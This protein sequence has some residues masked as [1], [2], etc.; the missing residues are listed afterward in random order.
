[1][2][3]QLIDLMFELNVLVVDLFLLDRRRPRLLLIEFV[4]KPLDHTVVEPDS[5][6]RDLGLRLIV[7]IGSV[8]LLRSVY[9]ALNS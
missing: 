5:S 2:L 3:L 6:A 4:F 7:L 8:I 9:R 1:M